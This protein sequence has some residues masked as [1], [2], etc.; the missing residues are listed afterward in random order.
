MFTKSTAFYDAIYA[1]MGK[2]YAREAQQ[3]HAIIQ[4]H[5]RS[6][7][8][9]LLDV[10]C[11]TGAHLAELRNTYEVEGLDLDA[12]MLKIA[13]RRCPGVTFHRTD[14]V[15]FDLGRH[16]DVVICMFSSIGYAKTVP[17]LRKTLRTMRKHVLPGG[18]VIVEP[19]LKPEVFRP[20]HISAVFVDQPDLKIARM[21]TSTLKDGV[22]V[23]NFHYLV[24]T[25][26]GIAHFTEH[27][28]LGLY[29]HDDYLA[30]YRKN[31]LEVLYESEGPMGRGLYIGL[32]P[33]L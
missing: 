10:A 13:K 24:T 23:L 3:L 9:R 6:P 16:Y 30:A 26:K 21:N 17:R 20:G 27:H 8:N 28:E 18:L 29:T 2:D 5:K 25:L 4:E 12:H 15:N 1:A 22:S 11:G 19:W 31:G 33:L 14:M 32:R 7:G